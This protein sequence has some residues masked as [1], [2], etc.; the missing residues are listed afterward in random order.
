MS[1]TPFSEMTFYSALSLRRMGDPAKSNSLAEN[2]SAY[3]SRQAHKKATIDYFA[4]SL[5]TML[6]FTDDL[7]KR[8]KIT[9]SILHAQA[10]LLQGSADKAALALRRILRSDPSNEVAFDMLKELPLHANLTAHLRDSK[11]NA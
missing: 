7:A 10:D 1:V 6:L 8:Q 9:A 5:P 2:L 3:S 4:T 11:R